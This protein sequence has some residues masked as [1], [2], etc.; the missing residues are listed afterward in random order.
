MSHD[1]QQ[2]PTVKSLEQRDELYTSTHYYMN[3][4]SPCKPAF[5]FSIAFALI[6]RALTFFALIL[7]MLSYCHA[8][9]P[10][11][12]GGRQ[13]SKGLEGI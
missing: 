3:G 9:E 12:V 2:L 7:C 1:N 5:D 6:K 10:H 8:C 11:A 13:A 4:T